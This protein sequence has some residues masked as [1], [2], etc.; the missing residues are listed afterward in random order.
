MK[1]LSILTLALTLSACGESG[2]PRERAEAN[3]HQINKACADKMGDYSGTAGLIAYNGSDRERKYKDVASAEGDDRTILNRMCYQISKLKEGS[4]KNSYTV[5]SFE[6]EPEGEQT[7]YVLNIKYPNNKQAQ[8]AFI[9][10]KGT[11]AL[12]DID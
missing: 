8:F 11:M 6:E 10:I 7:W 5:M 3:F 4:D 1:K 2:T 12:G 9:D